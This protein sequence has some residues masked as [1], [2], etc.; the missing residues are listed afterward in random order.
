MVSTSFKRRKQDEK[1]SVEN[2]SQTRGIRGKGKKPNVLRTPKHVMK[3]A[4]RIFGIGLPRLRSPL[5]QGA[6]Q[7]GLA[8]TRRAIQHLLRRLLQQSVDQRQIGLPLIRLQSRVVACQTGVVLD[9]GVGMEV[10]IG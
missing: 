6:S 2:S 3:E 8:Q 4:L 10:E 9:A 5:R 1:G 7:I